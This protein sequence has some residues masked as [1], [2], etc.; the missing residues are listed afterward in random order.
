MS[1]RDDLFYPLSHLSSS[2]ARNRSRVEDV[3]L[4]VPAPPPYVEIGFRLGMSSSPLGKGVRPFN[5]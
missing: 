4:S 2:F 3:P 1:P 5:A